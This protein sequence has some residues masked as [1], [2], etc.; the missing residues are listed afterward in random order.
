M[1]L[2]FLFFLFVYFCSSPQFGH[3]AKTLIEQ[4]KQ[5]HIIQSNKNPNNKLIKTNR[6]SANLGK[7]QKVPKG[8]K[9]IDGDSGKQL[10]IGGSRKKIVEVVET[11]AE[12]AQY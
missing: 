6:N 10:G 9:F 12:I 7:S 2:V 5:N 8:E 1:L 4:Q 11:R 3:L